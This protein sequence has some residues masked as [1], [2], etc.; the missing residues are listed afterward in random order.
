MILSG[1]GRYPRADCAVTKMRSADDARRIVLSETSLIARGNGR[2]YGD[3]ALNNGRVL[4][5][6]RFDRI[7]EFDASLGRITCEAGLLLS[8]LLDFVVPRGLFP[9]VT[10]G[11]KFVTIGG[12]IASDVHGKNH[13]GHGTFCRYVDSLKIMTA[14]GEIRRCSR[15]ENF[16]LFTAV[17]GGM[18]LTGII[19]EASFR[20]TPVESGIIRQEIL[21]AANLEEIMTLSE[22]SARST[23][24]VAWIDCLARG[25]QLGRGLVYRGEHATNEEGSSPGFTGRARTKRRVPIDLPKW[26]INPWSVR[27]FNEIYYRRQKPC[28]SL[29]DYDS[30]FYPLDSILE[31]NRIYGRRGMIQYQCA[32][33]SETS[34]AGV[35]AIMQRVA[36]SGRGSPLAV[37][38]LFGPEGDGLLSFPMEGYTV[39]LDFPV[40]AVTFDVLG[41]LDAIVTDHGG[42]LYLAKDARAGEEMIRRG[43]AKLDR[44]SAVR[45]S[46]DPAHK[47]ASLQSER[48][49]L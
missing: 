8:D 30:Y 35:E 26:I 32:L 43:Y 31:W 44:F 4:S 11:T 36:T 34:R 14:D 7:T 49:R 23:Y 41:E 2:S 27:A 12:M 5:T 33:P 29:I 20:L 13:H 39:T 16:E 15:S 17:C 40:D 28:T 45:N 48:L 38:K 24:V 22:A 18:G 6:L 1:W 46:I 21:R 3:A 47:F 19:L 10:P 9:P 37:L 25:S 42:R